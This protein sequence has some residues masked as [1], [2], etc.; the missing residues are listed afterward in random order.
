MLKEVG[1]S[2]DGGRAGLDRVRAVGTEAF[3]TA[4]SI[5]TQLCQSARAIGSLPPTR[6]TSLSPLAVEITGLVI[7]SEW[8]D[9]SISIRA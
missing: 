5:I 4:R 9:E 3:R 8:Q 2:L 1:R 7:Y 6:I